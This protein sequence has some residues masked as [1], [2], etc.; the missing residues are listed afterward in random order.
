[1]QQ[2]VITVRREESSNPTTFDLKLKENILFL[3]IMVRGGWIYML[4]NKNNT[5]LYIGVTSII[6]RRYYEHVH[7]VDPKS[8]S[9]RYN[10]HKLV[11]FE[12]FESIEEAIIR[13]KKLKNTTRADKENLIN[14]K[15]P[16]WLDMSGELEV[17]F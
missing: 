14:I 3:V 4:T 15:N 10:L 2:S 17:D 12:K 16:E 6:Y 13:E 5:V 8:F 7:R 9:A 11:Y 1:L